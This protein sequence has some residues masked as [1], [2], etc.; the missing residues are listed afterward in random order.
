[1]EPAVRVAEDQAHRVADELVVDRGTQTVGPPPVGPKSNRNC[2][3]HSRSNPS[4]LLTDPVRVF[5]PG[6]QCPDALVPGTRSSE[7]LGQ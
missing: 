1:M 3:H 5:Q 2:R 4:L 7:P 6:E